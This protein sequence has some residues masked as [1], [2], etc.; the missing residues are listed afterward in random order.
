MSFDY[1]PLCLLV[2]VV[3]GQPPQICFHITAVV[4]HWVPPRGC[5]SLL[6]VR[7]V[8]APFCM[9]SHSEHGN[10]IGLTN[11]DA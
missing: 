5:K 1:C 8:L 10:A 4:M 3:E 2:H 6:L 11:H 7:R 9:A